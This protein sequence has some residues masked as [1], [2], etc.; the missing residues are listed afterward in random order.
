MD[1]LPSVAHLSEHASPRRDL[2]GSELADLSETMRSGRHSFYTLHDHHVAEL[3][4][5]VRHHREHVH[6]PASNDLP[7]P[8]ALEAGV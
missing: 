6:P 4:G 5:A 7:E 8:E 2:S 3:L 1:T